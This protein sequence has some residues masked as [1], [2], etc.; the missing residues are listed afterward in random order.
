MQIRDLL[1][2]TQQ[3]AVSAIGMVL[4]RGLESEQA[5]ELLVVAEYRAA[6]CKRRPQR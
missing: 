5:S 1:E 3:R 4:E 6:G 2:D